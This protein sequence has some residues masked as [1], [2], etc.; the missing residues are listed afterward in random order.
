MRFSRISFLSRF[1]LVSG[2][3]M[4]IILSN[5]QHEDPAFQSDHFTIEKLDDGIYAAIH[6]PGGEAI[7]NAGIID[8]G[9]KTLV[10]DTFL[11]PRA[12]KD[13]KKQPKC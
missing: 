2:I 12:A 6:K 9:S 11:T 8:L 3:I 1:C 10:F 7:C 13:L 5:C 4:T